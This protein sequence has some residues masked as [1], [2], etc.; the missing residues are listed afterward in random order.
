MAHPLNRITRSTRSALLRAWWRIRTL[1]VRRS[2][3]RIAPVGAFGFAYDTFGADDAPPML[4][5]AGFGQQLI[6]W[7]D[8]FCA[9]L[10]ANGFHVIR[11]DHRDMGRSAKLA[12]PP[13]RG[14]LGA[15]KAWTSRFH[16]IRWLASVTGGEQHT[17]RDMA[18][19]A[20][21]LLTA[22]GIDSAHVIG[23]SMGG[24]IAQLIAIHH[25]ERVRTLTSLSSTTGDPILGRPNHA[26]LQELLAPAPRDA[27]GFA[28]HA[29][30]LWRLLRGTDDAFEDELERKRALRMY[31]RG[32]SPEAVRRQLIAVMKSRS[33]KSALS[34][35]A[36]P[37]LVIH[38]E[39]DPLIPVAAAKDI[40]TTIPGAKLLLLPDVGH[41]LPAS[42][43]PRVVDAIVAHAKAFDAAA[44][45][46][47]GKSRRARVSMTEA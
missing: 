37:T 29:V 25:P 11:F 14:A 26:A 45:S 1:H 23:V 44:T 4:L 5:I 28:E 32:V 3:E 42:S 39:R 6:A 46:D 19:D 43:W 35:V 24:M 10:A 17:L 22:L 15:L 47:R 34:A 7:D 41:A 2:V 36:A 16:P 31:A 27:D 9:L 33:W 30:A 13:P 12:V 8:S 18:D 21:G 38:G 40:A 20:A